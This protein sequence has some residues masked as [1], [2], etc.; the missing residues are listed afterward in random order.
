MISNCGKLA[1]C[2]KLPTYFRYLNE[3]EMI[4]VSPVDSFGRAYGKLSPDRLEVRV[5]SDQDG[6]YNVL[7]MGTR[8]DKNAKAYWKGAERMKNGN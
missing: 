8:Y 1:Q 2:L 5:T 3:N 7:V 4:W 6:D